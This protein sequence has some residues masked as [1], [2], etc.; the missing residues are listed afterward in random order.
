MHQIIRISLIKTLICTTT[1]NLSMR[2]QVNT[3]CSN[4]FALRRISKVRRFLSRSS[5]EILVHAFISSILD[6]YCNL[7]GIQDKDI[8]KLQ[9][10]QNSAARLVSLCKKY[11]HITPIL[12]GLHWLPIKYRIV[13]KIILL[14]F[15][16]L[17]GQSP[18][19]LQDLVIPYVPAR[20]L[21]SASQNLLVVKR[22]KTKAY[23]D[24]A[25]S[26]IAPI[27]WNSL[28]YSVRSDSDINTFQTKLKTYL[29]QKSYQNNYFT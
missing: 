20:S 4:S 21:R 24:R 2:N 22:G 1:T 13:Y 12:K 18:Q 15:K 17:S 27:L 28:P 5:T 16:C 14:T 9:R 25:F 26:C 29:F 6:N 10:I 19:Y 23:G 3:M 7:I 8:A 11:E